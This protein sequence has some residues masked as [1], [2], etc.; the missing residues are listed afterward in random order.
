MAQLK[1]PRGAFYSSP[2]K[3]FDI[4]SPMQ[5]EETRKSESVDRKEWFAYGDHCRFTRSSADHPVRTFPYGSKLSHIVR[6]KSHDIHVYIRYSYVANPLSS[7]IEQFLGASS[8]TVT[9]N[10][11][12]AS[13]RSC[14]SERTPI[15]NEES[16]CIDKNTLLHLHAH[17]PPYTRFVS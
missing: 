11:L 12:S 6:G 10:S 2:P 13:R 9:P 3:S 7:P 17:D 14:S 15:G 16:A 8:R 1:K 4:R 5:L